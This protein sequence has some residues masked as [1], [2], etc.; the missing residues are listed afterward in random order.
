MKNFTDK[1]VKRCQNVKA[2]QRTAAFLCAAMCIAFSVPASAAE[3]VSTVSE[4]KIVISSRLDGAA[5]RSDVTITV[6]KAETD[7]L[8]KEKMKTAEQSDVVYMDKTAAGENGSYDFVFELENAGEYNVYIGGADRA[9]PEVFTLFFTKGSENAAAIAEIRAAADAA[10][11]YEVLS[12]ENSAVTLKLYNPVFNSLKNDAKEPLRLAAQ[13][14]Y[15]YLRQNT[16]SDEQIP[17]VIYSAAAVCIVNGETQLVFDNIDN[18]KDIMQLDKQGLDKYYDK[19]LSAK[20]TTMLSGEKHTSV[21]ELE[22]GIFS[23]VVLTNVRYGDNKTELKKML[24]ELADRLGIKSSKVTD[25]LVNKIIGKS[26]ESMAALKSYINEFSSGS[27]NTGGNTGGSDGSSGGGGGGSRGAGTP[28][29]SAGISN[30]LTQTKTDAADRRIFEDLEGYE[31]AEEYIQALFEKGIVKGKGQ[32]LFCPGDAVTREEFV[33]MITE[34]YSLNVVGNDMAFEDVSEDDWFFPYV[35]S[36]YY[37]GII[38]GV[39][40]TRFGAGQPITRQEMAVI[41]N[42]ASYVAGVGLTESAEKTVFADGAEIDDY[43]AEA[44]EKLQRAKI[45]NGDENGRF[46]PH[47]AATRAE[48]AKVIYLLSLAAAQ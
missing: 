45:L 26:F 40:E 41:A 30:T 24:T 6:V 3:N 29:V 47:G 11:V 34:A 42:R 23:T 17:Q 18:Y 28:A 12:R 8:D 16:V 14:I 43:A 20:Y 36:A 2:L 7:W 37:A 33:K 21:K 48:T 1:N 25:A 13:Y 4:G 31:W 38:N 44:V 15:D 39:S 32:R 46:N 9:E 35:K 19:A 27:G 22:D 5:E 10:A